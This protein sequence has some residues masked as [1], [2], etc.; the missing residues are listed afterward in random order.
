MSGHD[1][2]PEIQFQVSLPKKPHLMLIKIFH[3]SEFSISVD[4]VF[5]LLFFMKAVGHFCKDNLPAVIYSQ[6]LNHVH[7]KTKLNVPELLYLQPNIV[8]VQI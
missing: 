2:E 3:R 5:G 7:L 6:L 8:L 4:K 1:P